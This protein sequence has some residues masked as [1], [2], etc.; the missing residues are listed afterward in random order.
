MKRNARKNG[1]F[2]FDAANIKANRTD[3][4]FTAK[5]IISIILDTCYL[6]MSKV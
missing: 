6:S 2:F 3:F 1:R 5:N 4:Y